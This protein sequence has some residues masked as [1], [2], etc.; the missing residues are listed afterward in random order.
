M[1]QW[2]GLKHRSDEVPTCSWRRT[3]NQGGC[4]TEEVWR[5]RVTPSLLL[6]SSVLCESTEGKLYRSGLVLPSVPVDMYVSTCWD[7]RT[8]IFG[9]E[10]VARCPCEE[11]IE[12]RVLYGW[13]VP[14]VILSCPDDRTGGAMGQPCS[15]GSPRVPMGRVWLHS[16]HSW[17]DAIVESAMH[18]ASP[19]DR[20]Q[21]TQD[22]YAEATELSSQVDGPCRVPPGAMT[23][24]N[25]FRTMRRRARVAAQ[26]EA[27]TVT[28]SGVLLGTESGS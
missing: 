4:S 16:P 18:D 11:R 19:S 12:W 24:P 20:P 8:G 22:R 23:L 7:E 9:D 10:G 17:P 14:N 6:V 15:P 26:S 27:R 21:G 2:E 5:D 25:G 1:E 28:A 3:S 13:D